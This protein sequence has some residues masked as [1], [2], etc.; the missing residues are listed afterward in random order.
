MIKYFKVANVTPSTASCLL[1]QMN[2]RVYDPRAISNVVAKKMKM[3]LS[4]RGISTK[5]ASA[6][7]LVD[8]LTASPACSCFSGFMAHTQP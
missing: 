6:Q 8:C 4:E 1:H 7:V 5:A 2:D 3:W